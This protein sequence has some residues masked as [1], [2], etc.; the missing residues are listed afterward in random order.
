M[1]AA[2]TR[3]C[4]I[5]F[6]P[7]TTIAPLGYSTSERNGLARNDVKKQARL[8]PLPGRESVTHLRGAKG[9]CFGGAVGAKTKSFSIE[10]TISPKTVE[11]GL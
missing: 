4:V 11:N 6:R 10:R 7:T 9:G 5:N 8:V 2:E 3:F 1:G